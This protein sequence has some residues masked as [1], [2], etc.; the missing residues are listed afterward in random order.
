MQRLTSS[1]NV[2]HG[3]DENLVLLDRAILDGVVDAGELLEHDAAGTNVEVA[4]LGVAHL[5]VGQADVLARG[6][7]G[8]MR[9]LGVQTV[10]ERRAGSAHGVVGSLGRKAETVHDTQECGKMMVSHG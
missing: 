2:V 6:A 3:L 9:I 4:D 1:G 8:G 5:A 7:E 10:D